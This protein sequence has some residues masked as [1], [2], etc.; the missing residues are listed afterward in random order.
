M[1]KSL[2]LVALIAL[3]VL[4]LPHAAAHVEIASSFPERYTNV[5]PIPTQVWIEFSGKL[6]TL[7]GEAVNSIEVVDSTG[8]AV[9]YEDPVITGSKIMTK[10]SG[11]SAP[12]VFQVKYRVVGEDGH[13]IEGDYSFNASPDYADTPVV[14]PIEETDS[15]TSVGG[16]VLGAALLLSL[17]GLLIKARR[18]F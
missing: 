13:V 11:Q 14:M 8:I 17:I 9:S 10:V 16:V 7:D 18:Q 15:S 6:Q 1:R 12:G 3:L 2:G 5:N 4:C